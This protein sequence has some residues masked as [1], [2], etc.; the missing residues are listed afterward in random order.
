MAGL[1]DIFGTGGQSTLGLLGGTDLQSIR[2]D[3]QA[4][5]LYALAGRLFQGGNTGASIAQGLQMGQQAYK[6]AMRGQLEEQLQGLQVQDFL[7]KRKTEE[8]ALAR[9]K[10][11]DAAV[12]RSFQPGVAAQPA[13][14]IYG[15]DIMGQQV[16]EGM[17]PAI[18]AK[19]PSLDLQS[20]APALMTSREGRTTLAELAKIIPETRKAGILAGAQ[21]ENPFAI[22]TSDPSVPAPLRAVAEQYRKS[23]AAGTLDPDTA[24]K[25]FAELGQRVQAAQQFQQTQSGLEQQRQMM[26]AIAQGQLDLR[27]Q[28]EAN[29]PEQFSYSQKKD[30]DEVQTYKDEA[31]KAAANSAIAKRAA[32]L[33]EQAYTGSIE[34]GAKGILGAVGYETEAKTANDQLSRL[35]NQLAVNAPKFSGPTSDR[36][37]ARYDA[38]VGDLANPRKTVES[39][40]Q[41]LKDIIELSR[42]AEQYSTQAE[43]YFYNNNKSLRGFKFKE[44][45]YDGM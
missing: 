33:I 7:R 5:A 40:R 29:K 19:A 44:N 8:D 22:F 43:N 15:E 1:L 28:A 31:R 11:I 20:I 45:P 32:P 25:R 38:A 34:A 10:M 17:T 12:A 41:A 26:G 2:D 27:Q 21:Q 6:Q 14:E 9:Q 4:Q 30:F 3:A 16:G 24:D 42:K 37:A 35:S 36:D 23:F 13:Q 39:K 18:A